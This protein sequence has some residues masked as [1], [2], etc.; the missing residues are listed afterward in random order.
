MRAGQA[1]VRAVVIEPWGLIPHALRVAL[2]TRLLGK[3]AL[4]RIIPAVTRQ[5]GLLQTQERRVERS[6]SGLELANVVRCHQ[7][8]GV[9]VPASNFGVGVHQLVVDRIMNEGGRIERHH[10]VLAAE[11]V[12]V[13]LGAALRV[14]AGVQTVAPFDTSLEW[15]MAGKTLLS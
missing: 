2:V 7:I 11:V 10:L 6:V 14:V 13:A 1:V 9:A 5:A 15:R 12:A 4:M 3:L 8:G